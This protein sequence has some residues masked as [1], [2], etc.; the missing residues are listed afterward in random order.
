MFPAAD[1]FSPRS[2]EAAHIPS[3]GLIFC[4]P[5]NRVVG[6]IHK[7][8]SL[9]LSDF[10]SKYDRTLRDP[11]VGPFKALKLALGPDT[12]KERQDTIG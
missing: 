9:G 2:D 3:P 6:E 8:F 7:S 5:R 4:E 1:L 12:A 10:R 11:H